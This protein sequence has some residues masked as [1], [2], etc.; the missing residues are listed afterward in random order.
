VAPHEIQLATSG[1][2]VRVEAPVRIRIR[3][4]TK[5]YQVRGGGVLAVN[6]VS[7]HVAD[8]EIVVLLGPSGCGKTTLLRCV[9][10]LETPE[11]GE[12]EIHG[13]TVF[14]SARRVALP[15]ERRNLSMVFQS[16]ALWP[17]MSV[18]DNVAYPLKSR[19]TAK[20]EVRQRVENVLTMV[21]CGQL[22]GRY[23]G[24][25]SGGQ[26]QRVAL[27]RAMVAND[28]V[29]LF[30]EPLSNVDAKVREQLRLEL[31]AM[32]RDLR[33]SA[34]YVTHDQ[35]E[36]TALA[37]RI[38]V[39]NTGIIAQIGPPREVYERP[40]SRYVA[41]FVGVANQLTGAVV[42]RCGNRI[43]VRTAIGD[44][45]TT[46]ESDGLAEG[47]EAV[48]VFRPEHCRIT[49]V[50]VEGTDNQWPCVVDRTLF[51]GSHTEYLLHVGGARLLVW[52]MQPVEIGD[53]SDAWIAV[54][55]AWARALPK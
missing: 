49:T 20:S 10:G 37:D 30:D 23:P 27:A 52:S 35:S 29:V 24:Q 16:Y 18:F 54:S 6:D 22:S 26:Q 2:A 19:H 33:F 25:L 41:E 44:V 40:G 28:G 9:A 47:D 32:Q 15:P 43:C 48:V 31:V 38:A 11:S 42:E 13:Q 51:L 14:S 45:L 17:H 4:L 36:A 46:S 12:I 8:G 7:L 1:Q 3:N 53:G 21:N 34:L 50:P 5:R 55:P 39:M